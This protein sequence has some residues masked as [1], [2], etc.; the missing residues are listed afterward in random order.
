MNVQLV[1]RGSRN[2][3]R[4]GRKIPLCT[5]HIMPKASS[6]F[7]KGCSLDSTSHRM[8]PQL[9]TSHFSVYVSPSNT[10][11]KTTNSITFVPKMLMLSHVNIE[12]IPGAIQA[13]LPLLFVISVALSVTV[14]KSHIFNTRPLLTSSKLGGFKSRW[15]NGFGRIA[16]K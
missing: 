2:G 5:L 4:S 13:A 12:G 3:N 15:I 10:S 1:W 11:A 14:P 7:L 6:I 16:C 9:N 8:I